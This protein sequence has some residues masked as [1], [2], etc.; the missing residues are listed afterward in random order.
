ML[1]NSDMVMFDTQT[2]TWWQQ[3]M[4]EALVGELVGAKLSVIP[5]LVISVEE[6][7]QRYLNG[8]VL[9]WETGIAEVEK[10]YGLNPYTGYDNLQDAPY[11]SFFNKKKV[12]K[13]LLP[14][15]RVV[16]VES[17]GKRKVYPLPAISKKVINDPFDRKHIVVFYKSAPCRCWM[18]RK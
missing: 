11:D 14:M 2:E 12:D 5:S 13:R 6:F 18:R 16:D 3:L 9:S 4:G 1:R 8:K 7:F 10:S 15:E 17:Q